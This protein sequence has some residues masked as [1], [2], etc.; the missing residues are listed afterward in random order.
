MGVDLGHAGYAKQ[1]LLRLLDLIVVVQSR[2]HTGPENTGI[3]P[4]NNDELYCFSKELMASSRD[5]KVADLTLGHL[6]L[7]LQ[8]P[9]LILGQVFV[10]IGEDLVVF[11]RSLM[12]EGRSAPAAK[13]CP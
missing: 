12:M 9:G 2:P 7:T 11:S 13:S 10:H 1:I 4:W 3:I 5:T 6:D 8:A